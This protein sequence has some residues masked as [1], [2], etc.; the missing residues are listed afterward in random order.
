MSD[1]FVVLSGCSGGGKS[2]LLEALRRSFIEGDP[3]S[4]LCVEF[5]ADRA[6]DLPPRLAAVERD[7][8]DHQFGY[9]YHHALDLPAQAR[10]WS[11]REAGL[12]L[13]MAMKEDAKSLSFPKRR[14]ANE[15][16]TRTYRRGWNT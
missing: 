1:R 11:L 10:I 3:G 4:L 15:H 6:E 2:T 13:S 9:A 7:L 16:L 14:E 8:R 12:G 5:Y